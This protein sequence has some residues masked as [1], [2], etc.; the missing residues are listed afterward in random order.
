MADNEL[1][2]EVAYIPLATEHVPP[3]Y[4]QTQISFNNCQSREMNNVLSGIKGKYHY[5]VIE[6]T[7]V[8]KQVHVTCVEYGKEE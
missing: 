8:S 2:I 1:T 5:I 7:K 3:V 6:I 4:R